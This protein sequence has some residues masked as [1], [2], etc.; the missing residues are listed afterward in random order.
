MLIWLRKQKRL[1]LEIYEDY[2]DSIY[3]DCQNELIISQFWPLF[4]KIMKIYLFYSIVLIM[5]NNIEGYQSY[6]SQ[7]VTLYTYLLIVLPLATIVYDKWIIQKLSK[8]QKVTLTQILFI[9]FETLLQLYLQQLLMEYENLQRLIGILL[10]FIIMQIVMAT[11]NNFK[12]RLIILIK[13]FVYLGYKTEF[14]IFQCLFTY[15]IVFLNLLLVYYWDQQIMRLSKIKH[16]AEQ[17]L[18]SIPTAVCILNSDCEQVLFSN[19]YMKKLI[20]KSHTKTK[21]FMTKSVKQDYLFETQPSIMSNYDEIFL[22]FSQMFANIEEVKNQLPPDSSKFNLDN[23]DDEQLNLN[24]IIQYITKTDKKTQGKIYTLRC[25]FIDRPEQAIDESQKVVI[26]VKMKTLLQYEDNKHATLINLYDISTNLKSIYYKNLNQ[27][28]SKVIRSISHELRTRLNA[29]QGMI[30]MVQNYNQNFD[31]EVKKYLR[32]AFNNCRIQNFIIGSI[33][34][35]NLLRERKL[36]VKLEKVRINVL[37]QEVMDL[38]KDEAELKYIKIKYEDKIQTSNYELLDSE[39]FQSILIHIISNSIRFSKSDGLISIRLSK[40]LS[41]N[42]NNNTNSYIQIPENKQQTNRHSKLHVPHS[43]SPQQQ[44][45]SG[46]DCCH[47]SSNNNKQRRTISK[48]KM[49][50]QF[51]SNANLSTNLADV[52]MI[53]VRDNGLGMTAERLEYIR[54]LLNGEDFQVE[55]NSNDASSGMML[56]LRASNQL[57]KNVSGR[58]DNTNYISIDSDIDKGTTIQMHI[59]IRLISGENFSSELI[60]KESSVENEGIIHS[61]N[62][63]SLKLGP[64]SNVTQ[65]HTKNQCQ[66]E[67]TFMIVDD[68]PYNLIVLESLLKKLQHQVVKAENGRHC[69]QLLEKTF[70]QFQEHKCKG[71]KGII[72]DY[73]MPI[74]NGEEATKYITQICKDRKYYPNSNIRTNRV[75]WRG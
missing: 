46:S 18:R 37:I 2:N 59:K 69:I 23:M 39:K 62:N 11:M 13:F 6:N 22:F 14:T 42:N 74:M 55:R 63:F 49:A 66:C 28:K 60:L 29:I 19:R 26:E 33:I 75:F 17:S 45:L 40:D 16:F 54:S 50:S 31:W 7:Q 32:A 53:E 21:T 67:N 71:Y 61:Y 35:Y 38:F 47:D 44:R 8:R 56:G 52:Y 64:W 48:Y 57:I 3:I 4:V 25:Q 70:E 24:Q 10:I 27:F 9:L 68:E 65:I 1:A 73:Q 43:Y 15:H 36:P 12:L 5:I 20:D 58:D 72:M 30:Q 51:S 41:T 34:D